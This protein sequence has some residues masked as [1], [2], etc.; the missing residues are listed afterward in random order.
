MCS[1]PSPPILAVA[2][3]A[4]VGAECERGASM[5]NYAFQAQVNRIAPIG[6]VPEG[7]RIDVGF[8]G[9]M[10]DG[11]LAG[12]SIEGVDY[13]LIRPDGVAVIDARELVVAGDGAAT[14]VHAEGYIVPPFDMPPLEALLDPDFAWPDVDLP[15]HG[16]ARLQSAAPALA[17]VN[18][19]VYGFNGSVNMAT[20]SLTVR[21]ASVAEDASSP[22][23][24]LRAGYRAFAAGD[25]PAVLAVSDPDIAWHEPGRN[26]VAGDYKGHDEVVGFFA[27]LME[28]SGG[29]FALDVHHIVA[30]GD[31][32]LA[33]VTEHATRDG[34]PLS[35]SAVHA[36]RFAGGK[37]TE[38]TNHYSDQAAVDAF[39]SA[40][41]S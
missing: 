34:S 28:A 4:G 13:L 3:A 19:R 26:P 30:A 5:L 36:W 21:A 2:A 16:S 25:I 22:V 20:G 6:L 35:V 11:D 1:G 31:R 7:L 14:S 9:A 29:T 27:K 23:E 40:G 10:T 15:I 12:S 32:V 38:F 8:A 33:L 41:A 37:V 39:W 18:R 24:V 17:A